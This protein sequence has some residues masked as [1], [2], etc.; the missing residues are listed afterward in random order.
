MRRSER[1][2]VQERLQDLGFRDRSR[3]RSCRCR[4][5]GGGV[6]AEVALGMHGLGELEAVHLAA[7]LEQGGGAHAAAYAH[8]HHAE[9]RRR[10][11]PLHLV[12]KRRRG[13]RPCARSRRS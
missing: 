6:A 1:T 2:V 4:S 10:A 11:L 9:A 8:G 7:R 13:P 3:C 12:Q 5:D